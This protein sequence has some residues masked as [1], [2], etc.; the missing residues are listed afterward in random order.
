[1]I[2]VILF[3]VNLYLGY[4]YSSVIYGKYDKKQ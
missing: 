2:K 3:L 1:M 4:M